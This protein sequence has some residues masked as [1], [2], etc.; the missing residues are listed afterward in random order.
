MPSTPVSNLSNNIGSPPGSSP[1]TPLAPGVQQRLLL[2]QTAIDTWSLK[3][4]LG[5]ASAVLRS[6]DQNWVSVSRQMKP[7]SEDGR[8]SDWFSQKNCA[9]QYNLLLNKVDT[10]RRKRGEKASIGNVQLFVKLI[11]ILY[12][13]WRFK[14]VCLQTKIT[15]LAIRKQI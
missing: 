2:K 15:S 14:I 9:L 4:Q 13:R 6:G 7:F 5:L 3:E 11:F 12:A 1:T 8:P 10:P